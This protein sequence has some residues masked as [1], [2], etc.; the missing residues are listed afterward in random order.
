MQ[1]ALRPASV[2]VRRQLE[3]RAAVRSAAHMGRA[4]EISGRIEDQ[5]GPQGVALRRR[6]S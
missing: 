5:A 2:R 4:V 1:H 6:S 3:D